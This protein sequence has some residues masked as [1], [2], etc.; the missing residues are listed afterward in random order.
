MRETSQQTHP[1][2]H[3]MRNRNK[4]FGFMTCLAVALALLAALSFSVP[5]ARAA[6]EEDPN[7]PALRKQ[8]RKMTQQ[9]LTRIR[10]AELDSGM[11]AE[12]MKTP[13]SQAFSG[14]P[15]T[16]RE[17]VIHALNRLSFGQK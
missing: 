4:W 15:L 6:D 8:G 3:A 5:S 7:D 2:S 12:S 9:E 11:I 10:I 13:E 17:K 16:D 14:P 1:G